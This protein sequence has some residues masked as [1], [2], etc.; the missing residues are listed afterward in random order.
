MP[1][2]RLCLA[3]A[4]GAAG[5]AWVGVVRLAPGQRWTREGWRASPAGVAADAKAAPA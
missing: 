2:H 4:A 5:S 3:L 1:T